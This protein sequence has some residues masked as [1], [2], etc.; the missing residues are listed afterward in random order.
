MMKLYMEIPAVSVF[1]NA[2][3]LSKTSTFPVLIFELRNL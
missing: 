3:K 1:R 2:S